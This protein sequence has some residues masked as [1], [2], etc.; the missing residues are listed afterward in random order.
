VLVHDYLQLDREKV[1]HI[2]IEKV[3]LLQKMGQIF[4]GIL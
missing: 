3:Q 4:S 2:L 1:Y